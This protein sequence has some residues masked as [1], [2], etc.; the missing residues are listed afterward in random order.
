VNEGAGFAG[1]GLHAFGGFLL[2]ESEAR[3]GR[4][5]HGDFGEATAEVVVEVASDAGAFLGECML[6]FGLF[7]VVHFLLELRGALLYFEAEE[8]YPDGGQAEATDK[9]GNENEQVL[10][11]PE[12]RPAEDADIGGGVEKEFEVGDIGVSGAV[13]AGAGINASQF[14]VTAGGEVES[15]RLMRAM[16]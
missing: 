1:D 7:T 3:A 15:W 12:G 5:K 8:P 14:K 13:T 16:R 11:V 9:R 4:G 2:R 10:E 6:V